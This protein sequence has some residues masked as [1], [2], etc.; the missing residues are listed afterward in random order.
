MLWFV[1]GY[2]FYSVLYGAL[3]SLA[4]RTEDAQAAT[5]PLT[6]LLLLAY[7]GAFSAVSTP[8][9]WWVTAGSLFPP[10]AP[11]F[12]PVRAGLTD[13]PIWQ[14]LAAVGIMALAILGMVQIGGRLYRG[15]VLHTTGRL[16]I[17]QA[18]H[19]AR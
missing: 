6:G 13:V 16:R 4:T 9:G 11:M 7:F 3:G 12:M 19:Q 1:L 10:T 8:T 5:T 2:G 14:M 17:R 18:W 15:A